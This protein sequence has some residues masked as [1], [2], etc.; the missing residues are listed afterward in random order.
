[1][2]ND[3]CPYARPTDFSLAE[4][5]ILSKYRRRGCGKGFAFQDFE[6]HPICWQ[7]TRHPKKPAS[8]AFGDNVIQTYSAGTQKTV[9]FC[10]EAA[11]DDGTPGD[12]LY[13]SKPPAR[14]RPVFV[15]QK[16]PSACFRADSSFICFSQRSRRIRQNSARP[17]C[18]GPRP[19]HSSG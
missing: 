4:F 15:K 7:L 6:R 12:L 18:A 8:V 13:C 17:L 19:F 3:C 2:V 11:C 10:P 14:N 9:L 16:E 5:C 1:M